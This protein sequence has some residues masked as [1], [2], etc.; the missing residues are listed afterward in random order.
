[1]S[2]DKKSVLS[3][4]DEERRSKS[5][6]APTGRRK[7]VRSRLTK[8]MWIVEEIVRESKKCFLKVV[9]KSDSDTLLTVFTELLSPGTKIMTYSWRGTMS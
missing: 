5:M 7:Y 4:G 9:G 3:W 1:M 6:K 2:S 8:R